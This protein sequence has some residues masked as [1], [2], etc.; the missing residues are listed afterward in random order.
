MRLLRYWW[1]FI[2]II[3]FGSSFFEDDSKRDIKQVYEEP[4]NL[5]QILDITVQ[6][7][8]KGD[9]LL[10]NTNSKDKSIEATWNFVDRYK[11]ALNNAFPK[12]HPTAIGV[13]PNQDASFLAW[14]DINLNDKWEAELEDP[15][16]L[17]EIDQARSRI[18][19]SSNFGTVDEIK[20]SGYPGFFSGF[21]VSSLLNRQSAAGV[22]S[23]KLAAKK[24]ISAKSAARSRA[25]SGS[26]KRGK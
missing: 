15:I 8:L 4:I 13:R 23:Q 22:T 16:F 7:L 5:K 3:I 18:I 9:T 12:I 17:I 1:L 10:I 21:L 24:P 2:I 20:T 25:G 19:A 11:I 26:Y 14:D 6:E